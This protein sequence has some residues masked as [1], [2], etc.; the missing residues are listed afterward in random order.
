ML[1]AVYHM[2]W[3]CSSDLGTPY[4]NIPVQFGCT[5][6]NNFVNI[7]AITYSTVK[8]YSRLQND[9]KMLW[10]CMAFPCTFLE[11]IGPFSNVFAI[12]K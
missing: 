11:P 1:R 2:Q 4:R 10:Y 3:Q 5:H 7:I 6:M 8:S 12:R 9:A